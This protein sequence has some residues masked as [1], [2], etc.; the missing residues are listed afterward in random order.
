MRMHTQRPDF[1]K[2]GDLFKML[3]FQ[4][5]PLQIFFLIQTSDPSVFMD[6]MSTR[7]VNI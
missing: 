6:L 7:E 3:A 5:A 1:P 2:S 4:I